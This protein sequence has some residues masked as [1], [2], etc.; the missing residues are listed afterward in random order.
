MHLRLVAGLLAWFFENAALGRGRLQ[1]EQCTADVASIRTA[2]FCAFAESFRGIYSLKVS[3]FARQC[4]HRPDRDQRSMSNTFACL[5][6][7]PHRLHTNGSNLGLQPC[8][9]HPSRSHRPTVRS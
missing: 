7:F 6:L 8:I 9:L 3:S 1:P 2:S 4:I 5:V